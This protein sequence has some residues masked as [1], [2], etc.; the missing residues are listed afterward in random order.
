MCLGVGVGD[1]LAGEGTEVAELQ[2]LS[3][4]RRESDLDNV[5]HNSASFHIFTIWSYHSIV[6]RE[7]DPFFAFRTSRG[8]LRVQLKLQ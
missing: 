7:W 8:P 3:H 4:Q 6:V 5:I 2:E 1:P